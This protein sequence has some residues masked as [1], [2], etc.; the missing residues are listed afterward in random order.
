MVSKAL[1]GSA[2]NVLTVAVAN[3]AAWRARRYSASGQLESGRN[4]FPDGDSIFVGSESN[5]FVVAPS[6]GISTS[7]RL[8]S[9]GPSASKAFDSSAP[10]SSDMLSL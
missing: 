7:S 6:R 1:R 9:S 2:W 10:A 3:G 8:S 4:V 5:E